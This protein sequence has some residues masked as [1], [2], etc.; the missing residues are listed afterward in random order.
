MVV[1]QGHARKQNIP[2][3]GVTENPG[4]FLLPPVSLFYLLFSSLSSLWIVECDQYIHQD[5][6]SLRAGSW[7]PLVHFV[8]FTATTLFKNRCL[9]IA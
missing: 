6:I 9:V 1:W 2:Y 7:G 8:P 4:T 5:G 3:G